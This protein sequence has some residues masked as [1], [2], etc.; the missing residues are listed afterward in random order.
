MGGDHFAPHPF[1]SSTKQKSQCF[2]AKS[3]A[4]PGAPARSVRR[5]VPRVGLD[6]HNVDEARPV[7][8]V[9]LVRPPVGKAGAGGAP[10]ATAARAEGQRRPTFSTL[11]LSQSDLFQ[12]QHFSVIL[13]AR[14]DLAQGLL[15]PS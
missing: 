15:V 3:S 14:L 7:G 10:P 6:R 9:L 2:D 5:D 13:A 12:L 4:Q 1:V 11:D 8:L